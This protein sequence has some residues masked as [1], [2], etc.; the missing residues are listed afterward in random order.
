M[1]TLEILHFPDPRLRTRAAP[2]KKVDD[3]VRNLLKDMLETMYKAEGIGLAATQINVHK[4]LIV[5]DI[6]EGRNHPLF[7]I[8][9]EILSA[10]GKFTR[11]K[12]EGCLSVPENYAKVE[13]FQKIK[14]Q[15][16]N[17]KAETVVLEVDAAQNPEQELLCVCIQHEM[18]HL[19][20]KLFVDYLSSLKR[21][22][23]RTKLEKKSRE[24]R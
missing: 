18:D 15:F 10:E 5:I 1:A 3:H 14:I 8:N 13:R 23:I 17:E 12:E 19:N 20:G 7:L 2:V 21:Q 16:L 24:K 11:D 6:S 9:P 4:K 22:Q